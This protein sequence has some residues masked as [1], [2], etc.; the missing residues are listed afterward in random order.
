L[1]HGARR[2][3]KSS[4]SQYALEMLVGLQ[5]LEASGGVNIG[6]GCAYDYSTHTSL[7]VRTPGGLKTCCVMGRTPVRWLQAVRARVLGCFVLRTPGAAEQECSH[8]FECTRLDLGRG[9]HN[10]NVHTGCQICASTAPAGI[11][12]IAAGSPP[13]THRELCRAVA[14]QPC[15]NTRVLRHSIQ[16]YI[17]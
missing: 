4:F 17:Q 8:A 12:L 14:P 5:L 1:C 10:Y 3:S 7:Y 15:D 2:A 13:P 16:N 11:W 9:T 6:R